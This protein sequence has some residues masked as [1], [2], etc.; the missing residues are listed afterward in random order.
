MF[1]Y[2]KVNTLVKSMGLVLVLYG[3]QSFAASVQLDSIIV[4]ATKQDTPASKVDAAILVKT[5]EELALAG[6]TEVA[7]L[8]KVFPG[9]L[10]QT[11]GNRTYASA[12]VRGI[13]SP[14]FYSPA[15]NV[16][17]DGVKQD[18]AFITQKLINVERVEF[19][20][21][22]Q[23]SL[24]GTNAQAGVINIIT[25]KGASHSNIELGYS[26]QKQYLQGALS[27][28]LSDEFYADLMLYSE[29]ENGFVDHQTSGTEDAN[30]SRSV[31][32][33]LKLNYVQEDG[34]WD[35][36]LSLSNDELDSHEE[37][38]LSADE[39]NNKT[40]TQD[41]PDLERKVESYGLTVNYEKEKVKLTSIS[42]LQNRRVDRLYVGG[43]WNEDQTV[44]SQEIKLATKHSNSL[45]SFLG[46]Y[47]ESL[48]F[49]GLAYSATNEIDTETVAAFGQLSYAI[50]SE[51]DITAGGRL[52]QVT[53][54]SDYSGNSS[55]GI[56]AY[57]EELTDSQFLPK[58]SLGWQMS[59]LTRVYVSLSEGYRPKGFNRVPFGDNS[60]GYDK[61]TSW[62][63]EL[64]WRTKL[65]NNRVNVS[66]ALYQIKLS[67][68]QLYS[69]S[70]PNQV[71]TNFGEA[72]SRGLEIE[73]NWLV[74]NG[75]GINLGGSFG[76]SE[77]GP[78]NG[79]YEGNSL[80]YTPDT[81]VLLGV[82]Y[83][84]EESG[85]QLMANT[86]YMS[87]VYYNEANTVSQS[88]ITLLD[89]AAEYTYK[90]VSY[91]VFVNNATDKEYVSY[92]YQGSSAIQSNYEQGREVGVSAN[93][94]W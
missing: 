60:A 41:I 1:R 36:V 89:L 37:W 73:L 68:V 75:V 31:N 85:L 74:G 12:S 70:I 44:T 29:D 11:R 90:N 18:N 57:D 48:E 22:S 4:N 49:Q 55:F 35:A 79:S 26:N 38:Y 34:P 86:R 20:K 84:H 93:Y 42:H 21:G 32:A 52:E 25:K 45:S 43:L 14:N 62:S 13:N 77:F 39:Y 15:I 23:G 3:Q 24:Y 56:A 69:G 66:G 53:T 87:K 91:R 59:D 65:L 92:S 28:D 72:T 30:S 8:E 64:G 94:Q 17:V 7:D 9:L 16:L 19:L 78:G 54:T 51:V 88:A 76:K 47:L 71:L 61:E 33:G 2:V 82:D 50:N 6:V 67:D 46:I 81:T 40:T 63:G 5:A 80:T 58:V 27:V 83:K 10:I